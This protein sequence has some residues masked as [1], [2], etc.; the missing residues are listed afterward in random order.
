[1]VSKLFGGAGDHGVNF[2]QAMPFQPALQ[3]AER[4]GREAEHGFALLSGVY[5]CGKSYLARAIV[6]RSIANGRSALFVTVEDMMARI[7]AGFD[8]KDG[9]EVQ[10]ILRV[11]DTLVIDEVDRVGNSEWARGTFAAIINARYEEAGQA[12]TVMTTNRL[13]AELDGYL[14]SRLRD[15]R[16]GRIFQFWGDGVVDMRGVI[17]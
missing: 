13:P 3:E 7:R 5:G 12:L 1:M 17:G 8:K 9:E 16:H 6:A 14:L 11:L 10:R 2:A 4:W 15:R